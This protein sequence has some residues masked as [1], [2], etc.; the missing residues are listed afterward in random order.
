[1]L[2]QIHEKLFAE[3]FQIMLPNVGQILE[4]KE[5]KAVLFLC[6]TR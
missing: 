1:M 5:K 6:Q 3:I 2:S 4:K